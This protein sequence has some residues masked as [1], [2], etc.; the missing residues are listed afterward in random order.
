MLFTPF[1]QYHKSL[2][3]QWSTDLSV[4]MR[5][6]LWWR[7][8]TAAMKWTCWSTVISPHRGLYCGQYPIFSFTSP[9]LLRLALWES[10]YTYI[11]SRTFQCDFSV[12]CEDHETIS[13]MGNMRGWRKSSYGV[14]TIPQGSVRKKG[15]CRWFSLCTE[16]ASLHTTHGV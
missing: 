2:I 16:R 12:G 13:L 7:P 3:S 10:M 15:T 5:K 4:K 11:S 14:L 1:R 9:L 6:S 8:L